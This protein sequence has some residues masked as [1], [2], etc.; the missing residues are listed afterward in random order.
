MIKCTDEKKQ[1]Y[2]VQIK[3]K[4][5]VTGKWKTKKKRGIHGKRNAQAEERT[6]LTDASAA[7]TGDTFRKMWKFYEEATQAT[8]EMARHY[9]QHFE[10]RFSDFLDR[11]IEQITKTQLIGWRTELGKTDFSTRTKNMTISSVKSVFRFA[12][13]TYGIPDVASSLKRFKPSDDEVM[14][15]MNVWSPEQYSAF[16][17]CVDNRLYAYYFD[18]LFWTGMRRG[19]AIALQ[20]EDLSRFVRYIFRSRSS[21]LS[22]WS[23]FIQITALPGPPELH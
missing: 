8:P 12:A 16:R 4:D 11:P 21:L 19:E 1:I 2:F 14:T 9:K 15:E 3:V 18:T 23:P 17:A 7:T 22:I 6:M 13:E 20:K 5:P 10:Y